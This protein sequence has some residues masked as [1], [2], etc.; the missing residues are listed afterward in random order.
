[1]AATDLNNFDA[2]APLVYQ[3]S[4]LVYHLS[5]LNA[6]G[7]V[8]SMGADVMMLN[9]IIA[10]AGVVA[11]DVKQLEVLVAYGTAEPF[12]NR[13]SAWTFTLDGHK[14]YVLPLGPEGDWAFD[15]TTGTWCQLQT[16][17]FYGLNFTRG[18]MW[19]LRIMGGDLL[20]PYLYE[21]DPNQH[22][23]EDWR[24]INPPLNL[25]NQKTRTVS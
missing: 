9:P 5:V 1:M 23:D 22:Y 7:P 14:F 16:D 2:L 11:T 13:Q 21:M 6:F 3:S 17:G 20:Y 8:Q 24:A 12:D 25:I 19:G 15:T 18:V 4:P 10:S